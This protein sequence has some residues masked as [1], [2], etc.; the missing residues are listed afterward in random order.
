MKLRKAF[1]GLDGT[2]SSF[3]SCHLASWLSRACKHFRY[4]V[5]SHDT[6]PSAHVNAGGD[7][8]LPGRANGLKA[9]DDEDDS[10]RSSSSYFRSSSVQSHNSSHHTGESTES[11]SRTP[12]DKKNRYRVRDTSEKKILSPVCGL[13]HNFKKECASMREAERQARVFGATM[14]SLPSAPRPPPP[15]SSQPLSTPHPLSTMHTYSRPP[16][17]SPTTAQ[18]SANSGFRG[19]PPPPPRRG[20]FLLHIH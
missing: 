19:R 13:L 3:R 9:W 12:E 15:L 8:A 4:F 7:S 14:F 16:H 5:R 11:F 1:T 20:P 10:P 18:A 17:I 6:S 2:L